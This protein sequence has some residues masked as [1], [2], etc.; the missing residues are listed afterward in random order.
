MESWVLHLD[1]LYLLTM[2]SLSPIY[3]NLVRLM[4][5]N[6]YV[7]SPNGLVPIF[8]NVK[9]VKI[10]LIPSKLRE[11]LRL[12]PIIV[13]YILSQNSFPKKPMMIMFVFLS[14][15]SA[16][17]LT[18]TP[19]LTFLHD[20]L[21]FSSYLQYCLCILIL[22]NIYSMIKLLII[23]TSSSHTFELVPSSLTQILSPF[24]HLISFPLNHFGV[25]LINEFV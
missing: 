9:G 15:I 12:V 10:V 24:G 23:P 18:L 1:F 6:L 4:F 5:L 17:S 25:D 8:S 21:Y 20:L 11:I 19:L 22:S 3:P 13:D 2:L 7:K 14:N 16:S